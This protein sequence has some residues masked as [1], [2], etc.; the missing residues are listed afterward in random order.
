MDE[1]AFVLVGWPGHRN[2]PGRCGLDP[3][4]NDFEEAHIDGVILRQLFT[5]KLRTYNPI[6]ILSMICM[7]L[8]LCSP[9]FLAVTAF[10]LGDPVSLLVMIVSSP[11]W[12][13]GLTVLMNV[14]LSLSMN[15][16]DEYVKTGK[17][18]F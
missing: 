7:G 8:Y 15:I 11:Y 5:G 13:I 16:P 3:L 2:R 1:K 6:Y 12:V 4:D 9:L 17:S 10:F 18:F 14:Y